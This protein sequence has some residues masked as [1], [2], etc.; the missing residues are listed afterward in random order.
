MY[1]ILI[2]LNAVALLCQVQ[3]NSTLI[4]SYNLLLGRE[5]EQLIEELVHLTF[6]FLLFTIAILNSLTFSISWI[7]VHVEHPISV[8]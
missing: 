1:F 6:F 7:S 8:I 5:T 3:L 4:A 2:C